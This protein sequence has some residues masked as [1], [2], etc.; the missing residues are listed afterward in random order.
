MR[1]LKQQPIAK[2]RASEVKRPSRCADAELTH[3]ERVIRHLLSANAPPMPPYLGR[4][5]W[6]R[7]L[8]RLEKETCLVAAQ[9]KRLGTLRNLLLADASC[10]RQCA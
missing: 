4:S 10:R 2:S 6:L 5:Y 1:A 8:E 3:L 7:R 9:L